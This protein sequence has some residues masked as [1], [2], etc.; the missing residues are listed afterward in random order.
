M[1]VP[2]GPAAAILVRS[3][4]LFDAAGVSVQGIYRGPNDSPQCRILG[5]TRTTQT[6]GAP[7]SSLMWVPLGSP[8]LEDAAKIADGESLDTDL[9][10]S[11]GFGIGDDECQF[12]LA[13][14]FGQRDADWHYAIRFS[15]TF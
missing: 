13:K 14:P 3:G 6:D 1:P 2:R 8:G 12:E 4:G 7:A 9:K 10:A 5:L 15:E 11:L